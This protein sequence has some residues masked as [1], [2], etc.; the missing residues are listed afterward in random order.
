MKPSE[1]IQKDAARM[2]YDGDAVTRKVLNVVKSGAGILLQ[3]N[4]SLLL[5]IG[6]PNNSAELHLYTADSPL[7]LTKALKKFVEKIRRSDM[8]AV[9]GSGEIPQVLKILNKF[10]VETTKSDSP[11]YRW[12]AKV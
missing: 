7:N 8:N 12:M 5:L 4:D 2:G 6:L 1:I 9:Y 10:G 11:N 3:E